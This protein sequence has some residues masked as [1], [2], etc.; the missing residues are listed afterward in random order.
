MEGVLNLSHQI[1]PYANPAAI[2][3]GTLWYAP[4]ILH[5]IAEHT[6]HRSA[7]YLLTYLLT[8]IPQVPTYV[9]LQLEN[10]SLFI[11]NRLNPICLDLS[12]KFT[13]TSIYYQANL[14]LT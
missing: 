11:Q 6:E 3:V 1:D 9:K 4:F 10:E 14:N 13:H 12:S 8:I 5:L 2:V 7:A